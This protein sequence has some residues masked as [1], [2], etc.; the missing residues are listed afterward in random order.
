M[1]LALFASVSFSLF[2]FFFESLILVA[3]FLV[4]LVT[5]ASSTQDPFEAIA[6]LVS[7]FSQSLDSLD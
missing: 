3:K 6:A 7:R 1:L 5:R 4:A 2:G